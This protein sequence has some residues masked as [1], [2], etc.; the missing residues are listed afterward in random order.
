VVS[1]A[2]LSVCIICFALLC[3]A[4]RTG[5]VGFEVVE[6]HRQACMSCISMFYMTDSW[7][8]ETI[9]MAKTT[10]GSVLLAYFIT[11]SY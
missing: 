8:D 1:T 7:S 9:S 3:F 11:I 6:I 10:N 4:L 2:G 5:L